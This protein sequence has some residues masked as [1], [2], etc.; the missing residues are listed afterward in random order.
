MVRIPRWVGGVRK[1]VKEMIKQGA[2]YSEVEDEL[3]LDY[4]QVLMCEESWQEIHSS[5]DY[6]PD[7]ARPR[8]FTYEIDEVKTM[9]GP[10]VFELVGDLS[11]ADI[12]LLLL[13]VEGALESEEEKDK[14]N[15]LLARLRSI[16]G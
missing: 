14:A 10:R 13:H 12:E 5:F 6:T 1:D 15:K 7:E 4:N 16:V 2:S 3:G 11:D 8:E 9:L